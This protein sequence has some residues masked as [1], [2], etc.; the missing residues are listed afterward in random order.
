MS[1]NDTFKSEEEKFLH[2]KR[3]LDRLELDLNMPMTEYTWCRDLC[4]TTNISIN[5]CSFSYVDKTGDRFLYPFDNLG[6]VVKINSQVSSKKEMFSILE[7]ELYILKKV[8]NA[9]LDAFVYGENFLD[10][11]I[12]CKSSFYP[13]TGA[14][15]DRY[16]KGAFPINFASLLENSLIIKVYKQSIKEQIKAISDNI[17]FNTNIAA[18]YIIAGDCAFNAL[19]GHIGLDEIRLAKAPIQSNMACIYNWG[20]SLELPVLQ[21]TRTSAHKHE[22]TF[23]AGFIWGISAGGLHVKNKDSIACIEV[24]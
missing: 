17:M 7:K 5:Q 3:C 22:D 18:N 6:Q 19:K 8:F 23:S 4:M 12:F 14:I 13:D 20:E 9:F 2:F 1:D 16:K 10:R 21:L 24:V 11:S 15:Y